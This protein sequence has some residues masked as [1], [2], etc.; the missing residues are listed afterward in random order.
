[1]GYK[2]LNVRLNEQNHTFLNK[3]RREIMIEDGAN[4]PLNRMMEF[5]LIEFRKNNTEQEIKEKLIHFSRLG[6]VG[7]EGMILELRCD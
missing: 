3:I 1:M 4:I 7:R 2:Y 6:R 5:C